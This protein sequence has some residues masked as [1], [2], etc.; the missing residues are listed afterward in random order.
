MP[1]IQW[2]FY[3]LL[4]NEYIQV[5]NHKGHVPIPIFFNQQTFGDSLLEFIFLL[6][7]KSTLESIIYAKGYLLACLFHH[8]IKNN[9]SQFLNIISTFKQET[10]CVCGKSTCL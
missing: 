2:N 9:Y 8:T 5:L 1:Y 7:N 6:V 3:T 4:S 10:L